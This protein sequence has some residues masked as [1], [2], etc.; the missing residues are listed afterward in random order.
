MLIFYLAFFPYIPLEHILTRSGQHL[1]VYL[2]TRM[3]RYVHVCSPVLRVKVS[4][5][6]HGCS[7]TW[8][9]IVKKNV[10][11]SMLFGSFPLTAHP[12]PQPTIRL[13]G[14]RC[15]T[16]IVGLEKMFGLFFIQLCM[17]MWVLCLKLPMVT[18]VGASPDWMLTHPRVCAFNWCI[19]IYI[20]GRNLFWFCWW[21]LSYVEGLPMGGDRPWEI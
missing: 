21:W 20:S 10:W 6:F 11:Q 14:H 19:R 2:Y 5:S 17:Y 9:E 3:T 15:I 16:G 4:S 12:P 7:H 13:V 1:P 18:H 8:P